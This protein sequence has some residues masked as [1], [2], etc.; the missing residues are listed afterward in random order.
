MDNSLKQRRRPQTQRAQAPELDQHARA[1]ALLNI[2]N[3]QRR[4]PINSSTSIAPFL[5]DGGPG[6]SAV[7]RDTYSHYGKPDGSSSG[8]PF[9]FTGAKLDP[10]VDLP[11]N[12]GRNDGSKTRKFF[13]TDPTG[14]QNQRNLRGLFGSD[15]NNFFNRF[16]L[17]TNPTGGEARGCDEEGCGNFGAARRGGRLHEGVDIVAT[18]GSDVV[19][20]IS[21]TVRIIHAVYVNDDPDFD[22]VAITADDGTVYKVLYVEPSVREG[23]VV[24][25]GDI[26]GTA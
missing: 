20:P 18:A 4:G 1:V 14:D 5:P 8:F 21:G 13:T 25:E 3:R 9:R 22:G 19:A 12:K 16:R 7:E 24:A 2:L 23:D 17:Q 6:R 15:P 26:I 10:E 11:Y